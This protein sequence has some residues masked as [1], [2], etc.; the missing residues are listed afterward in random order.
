MNKIKIV[1]G[2]QATYEIDEEIKPDTDY[3]ITYKIARRSVE[4]PDSHGEGVEPKKFLVEAFS[5][6]GLKEAG[7]HEEMKI[8]IDKEKWSP[9]QIL[10][11]AIDES[12]NDF[13][14]NIEKDY[15]IV[16][17][18]KLVR[19]FNLIKELKLNPIETMD[20]FISWLENRKI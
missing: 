19:I 15:K 7:K 18:N 2:I 10:K 4:Q 16:V 11:L 9:S 12:L 20:K 6:E 14:I 8:D 13:T 5:I 1:K 3:L 17:R